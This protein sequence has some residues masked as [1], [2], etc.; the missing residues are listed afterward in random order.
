MEILGIDIG[1]SGIKG[2]PVDC[3]TGEL[4]QERHRLPTPL[5]ATP[6]AVANTVKKLVKH[7]KWQDKIGCGFPAVVQNQIVR[8]AANIDQTWIGVNASALF[9]EKSK[10]STVVTNDADAAGLAEVRFGAGKDTKG[11]VLVVTVGTGIGSALFINGNLVPNTEFGH[12]L[13][14][15]TIAEKWTSDAVRKKEDLSWKQW[16][17]RFNE[18]LQ[19]IE[20]LTWPD[21]IIIGGGVSK[22]SQ[23]YISEIKVQAEVVEAKLL[24]NA[25]IIGAAL[26]ANG[27]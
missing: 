1:G 7:F 17:K 23:K 21:K 4:L 19:H 25:G 11:V 13:F 27:L 20:R 22:K 26:S 6:E 8:T 16:A 5:P 9:E 10:C 24:N 14:K 3:N 2:A 15:N 12:L 18:Y